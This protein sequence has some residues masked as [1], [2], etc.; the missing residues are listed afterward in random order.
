MKC[1]LA[2]I[3]V[4][5]ILPALLLS[6]DTGSA[7]ENNNKVLQA[8]DISTTNSLQ[9]VKVLKDLVN[10]NPEWD[11]PWLVIGDIFDK[12]YSLSNAID[13]FETAL[14]LNLR[15]QETILFTTYN[16]LGNLY[17]KK[18]KIEISRKYFIKA[19]KIKGDNQLVSSIKN[20]ENYEEALRETN[21]YKKI[22]LLDGILIEKP[23]WIACGLELASLLEK[24]GNYGLA[25]K[26]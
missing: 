3:F 24:S 23:D 19:K 14:K 21:F 8:I 12:A 10:K 18:G 25:K 7:V 17:A 22:R 2:T 9:A 20:L 15:Q 5:T 16:R 11:Y 13:A 26:E 6:L 1:L 4:I